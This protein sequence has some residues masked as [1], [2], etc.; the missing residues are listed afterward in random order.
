MPSVIEPEEVVIVG[1]ECVPVVG[2]LAIDYLLEVG[3]RLFPLAV[4][5]VH[6]PPERV[7]RASGGSP[8]ILGIPSDRQFTYG[9]V[10]VFNHMTAYLLRRAARI[11]EIGELFVYVACLIVIRHTAPAIEH[12]EICHCTQK[13]GFAGN[14]VDGLAANR[15]SGHFAYHR[16]G[17]MHEFIKILPMVLHPSACR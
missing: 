4:E 8:Q 6:L 16:V 10:E 9:V 12:T 3:Y 14:A 2:R 13:F 11:P 15:H 7:R 1:M 5:E 17:P